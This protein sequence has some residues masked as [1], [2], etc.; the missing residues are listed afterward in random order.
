MQF[1]ELYINHYEVVMSPKTI[2]IIK[3]FVKK[4]VDQ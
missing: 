3:H 4:L 1:E 2:E